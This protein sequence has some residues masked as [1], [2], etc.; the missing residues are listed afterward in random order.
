MAEG[1][2]DFDGKW[3]AIGL[4]I[5]VTVG[6]AIGNI[7]LGVCLGTGIGGAVTFFEQKKNRDKK[8]K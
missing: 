3:I 6:A 4:A 5:G 2:K 7:S 8:E 1:K